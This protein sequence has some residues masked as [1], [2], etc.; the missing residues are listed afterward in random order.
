MWNKELNWIEWNMQAD[1]YYS[2][3]LAGRVDK[4][5][6]TIRYWT[7]LSRM[8]RIFQIY[9]LRPNDLHNSSDSSHPTQPHAIIVL[10]FIQNISKFLTMINRCFC[11]FHSYPIIFP[12]TYGGFVCFSALGPGRVF[13]SDRPCVTRKRY[14]NKNIFNENKKNNFTTDLPFF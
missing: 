11:T 13:R 3:L 12:L 1:H 10:S 9:P 6:I 7:R 5:K 2:D 4:N 14:M 8:L